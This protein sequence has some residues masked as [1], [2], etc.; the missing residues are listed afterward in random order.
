MSRV[1]IFH[2]RVDVPGSDTVYEA[3]G[4]RKVGARVDEIQGGKRF[5]LFLDNGRFAAWSG[6]KNG[7]VRRGR[8]RLRWIQQQI[9]G[10]VAGNLLRKAATG[11]LFEGSDW[12]GRANARESRQVLRNGTPLRCIHVDLKDSFFERMVLYADLATDRL[13]EAKLYADLESPEQ[14]PFALVYF[15]YPDHLNPSLFRVTEGRAR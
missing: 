8:S 12:I 6:A 15:D 2:L 1:P 4:E 3:W 13:T 11:R 5:T 7:D 14:E 9:N 10:L